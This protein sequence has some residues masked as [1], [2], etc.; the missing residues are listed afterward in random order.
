MEGQS[1]AGHDPL[2]LRS[3][4]SI[5]DLSSLACI[6]IHTLTRYS[7]FSTSIVGVQLIIAPL[8]VRG[9]ILV[10]AL[11]RIRALL[12]IGAL[13]II[14]ALLIVEAPLLVRALPVERTCPE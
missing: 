11:L 13:L 7:Y 14:R 2:V 5:L 8:I 10:M 12:I 3:S 9:L 4:F 6:R 1:A